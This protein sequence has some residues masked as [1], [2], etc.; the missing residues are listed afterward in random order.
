MAV[1]ERELQRLKAELEA[2]DSDRAR[3]EEE[4]KKMRA[5]FEEKVEAVQRHMVQLQKQ[6]KEGE[7][8]KR[9]KARSRQQIRALGE[10]LGRMRTMQDA[11][12]RK[13]KASTEVSLCQSV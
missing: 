2:I 13:I 9:E 10:E 4:K 6:L 8:A 12:K 3:T 1:K 11:L 5:A 7:A